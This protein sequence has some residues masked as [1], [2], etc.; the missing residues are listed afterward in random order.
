MWNIDYNIKSEGSATVKC[1][2]NKIDD[3][4]L[5]EKTSQ[6]PYYGGYG[7]LNMSSTI[8]NKYYILKSHEYNFTIQIT[9]VQYIVQILHTILHDFMYWG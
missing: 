4:L 7:S 8:S 3:I 9:V 2:D 1:D 6:K 5:Q